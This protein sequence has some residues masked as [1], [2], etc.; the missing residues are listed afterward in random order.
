MKIILNLLAVLCFVSPLANAH[1]NSPDDWRARPAEKF[2]DAEK[3]FNQALEKLAN[4]YVDKG[5][6]RQELYRAAT[7]G[8]LESLN[9]G[10]HSWNT[11]LSP[12]DLKALQGDL[13]GEVSGIG[14]S[15]KFE[16]AMGNGRVL[17]AIPKSP[18]KKAGL[19]RDDLILSV[20]GQRFKGKPFREMVAALRGKTGQSVD[21]KVLRDDRIINVT[22]KREVIA[23][24]PIELTKVDGATQLL[25][26]GYFTKDTP[27]RVEEKIIQFNSSGAKNLI[28]DLRDNSGGGFEQAVKTAELFIPKDQTIVTTK[29]REG[30]TQSLTSSKGLLKKDTKIVILT[31]KETSSGAELFTG[32]LQDQSEAKVVGETTLGKW[33]AQMVDT[34]PNGFAIKY[35][36]KSF[37]TPKGHSYQGVGL[38]PDVEVALPQ[39]SET[40]E[41]WADVDLTKRLE[42]DTQLRAARQL[43][44]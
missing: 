35:T 21:L 40:R 23:W 37:Q 10:E 15:L 28:I 3:S 36:V 32:A 12:A 38:K 17:G 43:I 42:S 1:T 16:E 25:T 39:G 27:T 44:R 8:M 20:N 30:K 24:T 5:I 11:L 9:S 34:L 22:V 29:D 13:S 18:A 33:N 6:T 7:A 2:T 31:N 14:I 19:K 26:I 41:L 4:E